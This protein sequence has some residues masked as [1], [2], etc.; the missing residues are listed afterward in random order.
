MM[1]LRVGGLIVCSGHSAHCDHGCLSTVDPGRVT[2]E[3]CQ[4]VLARMI[5]VAKGRA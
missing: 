1:H 3:Q 5:Q 2:C 4:R